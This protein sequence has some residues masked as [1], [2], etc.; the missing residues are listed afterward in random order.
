MKKEAIQKIRMDIV[1]DGESALSLM[2][3]KDGT[4]Y[5]QGN[6]SLPVDSFAV[7]SESDAMVFSQIID[8]IDE[9]AFEHAG[10][11]DHPD[12][13]GI[14]VQISLALLDSEGETLFFE[15]KYGTETENV[16]DLLPYID[17][18]ISMAVELTDYWYYLEKKKHSFETADPEA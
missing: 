12:K 4:I 17:K 3:D 14:P 18:L 6:G 2:L 5:R 8:N 13:Q 1:S 11:Y 7:N 9:R 16:G 15:F 10:V